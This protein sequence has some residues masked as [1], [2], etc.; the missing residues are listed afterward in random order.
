MSKLHIEKMVGYRDRV[1]EARAL[2]MP[3]RGW[4]EIGVQRIKMGI[5]KRAVSD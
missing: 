3:V 4:V 2:A 5:L 1:A